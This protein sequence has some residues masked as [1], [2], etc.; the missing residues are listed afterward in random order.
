MYNIVTVV[1]NTVLCTWNLLREYLAFLPKKKKKKELCEVMCVL[2]NL[3][4]AAILQCTCKSCCTHYI[5][6]FYL[7]NA[8]IK[9]CFTI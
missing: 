8:G 9:S 6:Q 7:S 5:C 1:N 4:M 3:I 2:I